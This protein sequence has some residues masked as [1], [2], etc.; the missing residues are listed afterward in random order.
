MLIR[1]RNV[2]K[3]LDRLSV[4][5]KTGAAGHDHF[6]PLSPSVMIIEL[7]TMS[8]VLTGRRKALPPSTTNTANWLDSAVRLWPGSAKVTR[9]ESGT[10]T[11]P[12]LNGARSPTRTVAGIPE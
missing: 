10:N 2:L 4:V 11:A 6:A 8:P 5:E 7:L 3:N 1:N 12:G 9:A